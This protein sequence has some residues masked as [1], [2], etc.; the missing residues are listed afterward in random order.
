MK[1]RELRIIL[2]H[3]PDDM[4]VVIGGQ[5]IAAAARTPERWAGFDAPAALRLYA[6]HAL[7][8]GPAPK[9]TL[10]GRFLR[11]GEL[12]RRLDPGEPA[13]ERS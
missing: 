7:H 1:V 11:G 8:G 9:Y 10:R 5:H 13:G 2:E 6:A 3:V 4:D 12:L